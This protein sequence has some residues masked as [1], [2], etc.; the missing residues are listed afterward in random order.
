[1]SREFKFRV[2]DKY[3]NQYLLSRGDEFGELPNTFYNGGT[4]YDLSQILNNPER[5]TVQQFTGLTDAK[6]KDVYEGDIIKFDWYYDGDYRYE[7]GYAFVEFFENAFD[8]E[9]TRRGN[10]MDLW[11]CVKSDGGVVVGNIFENP[12]LLKEHNGN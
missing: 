4:P 3:S 5:F 11:K 6:G 1:M 12:E 8:L 7:G 9:E 2:W 10:W